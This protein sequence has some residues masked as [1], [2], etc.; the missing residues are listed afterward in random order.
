MHD[1]M[2]YDPIESQGQ[3]HEPLK[4]GK[5]AIFKGYLSLSPPPFTMGAGKNDHG[6]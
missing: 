4:D 6:F 2:Q 3:G 5:L 1:G